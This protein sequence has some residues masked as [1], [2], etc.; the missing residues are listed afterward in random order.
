MGQPDIP[1]Q[2]NTY[3]PIYSKPP[4]ASPLP[5]FAPIPRPDHDGWRNRESALSLVQRPGLR[6][7]AADFYIGSIVVPWVACT[8]IQSSD[9]HQVFPGYLV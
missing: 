7:A 2:A 4:L 3:E 9:Y 8:T 5:A 1:A 6:V